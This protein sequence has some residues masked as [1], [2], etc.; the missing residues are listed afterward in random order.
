MR[1]GWL[2]TGIGL[3]IAGALTI[4]MYTR[5]TRALP[6]SGQENLSLT[7]ALPPLFYLNIP[8]IALMWLTLFLT[9]VNATSAPVL[10]QVLVAIGNAIFY[11]AAAYLVMRFARRWSRT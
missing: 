11:G 5:I 3:A 2:A 10:M 1:R 4:A 8:G 9:P 6:G 7:I